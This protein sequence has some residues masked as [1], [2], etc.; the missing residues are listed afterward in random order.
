MPTSAL[1]PARGTRGFSLVEVLVATA[2][3]AVAAVSL[4]QLTAVATAANLQAGRKS[5]AIAIAQQKIEELLIANPAPDVSPAGALTDRL[6]GWFDFVDRDGRTTGSGAV[7]PDG[8][9]YVRQWSV[10]SAIDG[11]AL[12][13]QVLVTDV[14]SAMSGVRTPGTARADQVRLAAARG[15]QAF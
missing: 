8:T 4:A 12:I 3:F 11:D 7:P 13:V 6:A 9:G 5:L 2:I 14:G 10:D 15:G 1:A